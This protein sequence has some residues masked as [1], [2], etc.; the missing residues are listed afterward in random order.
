MVPRWFF[1]L[2][3]APIRVSGRKEAPRCFKR[4]AFRHILKGLRDAFHRSACIPPPPSPPQTSFCIVSGAGRLWSCDHFWPFTCRLRSSLWSAPASRTDPACLFLPLIHAFEAS[5]GRKEGKEGAEPALLEA[6]SDTKGAAD[7]LE[8]QLFG[9]SMR[10]MNGTSEQPSDLKTPG[11][12]S[13]PEGKCRQNGAPSP[14]PA[15][16]ISPLL[17]AFKL[18]GWL[19]HRGERAKGSPGVADTQRSLSE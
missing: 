4:N 17:P 15:A 6:S 9:S 5:A 2:P 12:A 14:H 16:S 3:P 11:M 8:C 7:G 18:E 1:S 19:S 13:W 10:G